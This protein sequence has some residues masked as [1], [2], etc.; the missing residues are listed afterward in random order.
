MAIDIALS[1]IQITVPEGSYYGSSSP[2]NCNFIVGEGW[3]DYISKSFYRNIE[4][5]CTFSNDTNILRGIKV[6]WQKG[7]YKGEAEIT[8]T[9]K[10]LSV[11]FSADNN[12]LL[13]MDDSNSIL[14]KATS[15]YEEN[16]IR[17]YG[18]SALDFSESLDFFISKKPIVYTNGTTI[19]LIN[20][21]VI[22]NVDFV[23]KEIVGNIED[24]KLTNLQARTVSDIPI[25]G[26][27]IY[28]TKNIEDYRNGK[29]VNSNEVL[30][31]NNDYINFNDEENFEFYQFNNFLVDSDF[32]DILSFESEILE[33]PQYLKDLLNEGQSLSLLNNFQIFYYVFVAVNALKQESDEIYYFEVNYDFQLTAELL[34]SPQLID[35]I[36]DSLIF[37]KDSSGRY[38]FHNRNKYL[39]NNETVEEY[40]WITFKWYP[41]FNKN[42]YLIVGDKY[43]ENHYL[44]PGKMDPNV[45]TLC[46]KINNNIYTKRLIPNIDY[47][48][49]EEEDGRRYYLGRY[50]LSLKD[51]KIDEAFTLSLKPGYI[52]STNS[53]KEG[54]EFYF[55]DSGN[56]S[57]NFFL[58]RFIPPS[59]R[60]KEIKREKTPVKKFE[61]ILQVSDWGGHENYEENEFT[62]NST[63]NINNVDL[64][65]LEIT[66]NNVYGDN[67]LN[68]D[69]SENEKI[70]DKMAFNAIVITE[71]FVD[72]FLI[73]GYE[74]KKSQS[75][76]TSTYNFYIPA[77]FSTLSLRKNKVGINY[78]NM[79]NIE[80][81]LYVVAKDRVDSANI[82]EDI[83]I[84]VYGNIGETGTQTFYPHI[85]SI[86]G[87][88]NTK[89]PDFSKETG[90]SLNALNDN[91]VYMGFYTVKE[92]G[93]PYRVGSFGMEKG[94]PYFVY[95]G[96]YYDKI[97]DNDKTTVSGDV[98]GGIEKGYNNKN[99]FEKISIA[100]M[101]VPPGTLAIF[102][103][104]L[105]K[106]KNTDTLDQSKLTAINKTWFICNGQ[107]ILPEKNANLILALY[108][109]EI[110]TEEG[111]IDTTNNKKYY[112]PDI[113]P[114]MNIKKP[115]RNE[116]G[117]ITQWIT[118]TGEEE[119]IE[120]AKYCYIIKG[121]A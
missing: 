15:F 39:E 11:N 67:T 117:I 1:N 62:S 13:F 40:D 7:S 81:A 61:V 107:E 38:L 30:K 42:D 32:D 45:Y 80:E 41:A 26:F 77:F 9:S 118:L 22:R 109:E 17:F 115:I 100:D 31:L 52:D 78:S 16:N 68:F 51:E 14:F 95:K 79:T 102:P 73:E 25:A 29:L 5:N 37:E 4:I 71:V 114:T 65:D 47:V 69:F 59:I 20:S 121:D 116:A 120:S 57:V 6:E 58:S 60:L 44:L 48:E 33:N 53:L 2:V 92:D 50:A 101:P 19:P 86:Q 66:K 21:K 56:E 97:S 36:D 63:I 110:L 24:Y 12:N 104:A 96:K 111:K 94:Y 43:D 72:R 49:E 106:N 28:A 103:V 74:I 70:L 35:K 93:T 90:I 27:K 99:F 34:S 112:V 75:K 3:E 46:K 87:N 84:A 85:F 55:K 76:I 18:E 64:G 98:P 119:Q 105:I 82:G 54:K 113:R 23:E 88:K 8:G 108:G 91:S 10:V 89:M 83:N